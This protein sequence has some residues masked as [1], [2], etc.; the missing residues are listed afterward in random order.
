MAKRQAEQE[1]E[2]ATSARYAVRAGRAQL[3]QLKRELAVRA[4]QEA[5]AAQAAQNV[6]KDA[7]A[8]KKQK[9]IGWV[10]KVGDTV[11]VPKL[12]SKAR[13]V[14]VDAGGVLTLQAGLM[15]VTAASDEVRQRQ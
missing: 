6:A 5:A 8:L 15:K 2:A 14:G 13:V 3:A 9:A 10:P 11:F 1:V 4:A 12:N 7:A